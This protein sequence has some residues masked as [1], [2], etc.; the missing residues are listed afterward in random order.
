MSKTTSSKP[1]TVRAKAKSK[2]SAKVPS[3]PSGKEL[4]LVFKSVSNELGVSEEIIFQAMETALVA[5]TKKKYGMEVEAHVTIDRETGQYET[6]RY[7]VVVADADVMNEDKDISL[8]E[9][10][11]KNP[12]IEIGQE[13][14]EPLPSVEFGRIATQLAKQV[15]VKEVRKAELAKVVDAYQ[16]RIGELITG[17]VKKVTRDFIILDLGGHVEGMFLREHLLPRDALR[18]GDRLRGYLYEVRAE[19]RG[20]QLMLSR[21]SPEMLIELFKLEVPEI[22]EQLIEVKSAARD[23]GMRAKIAVKTNDGRIDPIGAC[24]GM[25]GSRVQSVSSELGGERIDIVLWDDNPAQLVINAMAPAEVS[26]IV[27]DEH[28]HTIDVA[29]DESQLSQA[30]GKNGQNVRLASQLTGWTL[31]VM[32]KQEAEQK[33]QTESQSSSQVFI[34]EL[35][36]DEDLAQIL[37]EQGFTNVEEIAYVPAKELLA[38]E[39]FDEEVVE[40]LRSRAK[41]VLLT[42][43]IANEEKLASVE[44]AQDLLTMPGMTTEL[45]KELASH[46]IVTREDLAE[47]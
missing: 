29:V 23:P 4:L 16:H 6:V 7:W 35:G 14:T 1:K 22:R 31:N 25:R 12:T 24:V 33:H 40:A 10:R 8:T 38:I 3:G 13:I 46:G 17:T 45:A 42:K 44:P 11:V 9:A 15:I 2:E 32:T 43:A 18:T 36:V 19:T 28:S 30:I 20:V 26:S 27:V 5:A 21:T 47:Q 41:D 39:G 37:V 34:D